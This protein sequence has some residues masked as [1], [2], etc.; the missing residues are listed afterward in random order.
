MLNFTQS[1]SNLP[2]MTTLLTEREAELVASSMPYDTFDHLDATVSDDHFDLACSLIPVSLEQVTEFLRYGECILPFGLRKIRSSLTVL[3]TWKAML[4]RPNQKDFKTGRP[5][6]DEFLVQL[7][8]VMITCRISR[9]QELGEKLEKHAMLLYSQRFNVS[10][11]HAVFAVCPAFPIVGTTPDGL[12]IE[13]DTITVVEVKSPGLGLTS[14]IKEVLPKVR[15]LYR[16]RNGH[17]RLCKSSYTYFQMQLTM[18][19]FG[20]YKAHLV[21]YSEFGNDIHVIYIDYDESFVQ[22][23]LVEIN[24]LYY[25]HIFPVVANFAI[26]Q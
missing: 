8:R 14:P 20:S 19:I 2:I 5:N 6:R 13:G 7:R 1:Y 16:A 25:N 22:K 10:V 26:K 11:K 23:K 9:P 17:Y 3:Y 15:S 24:E 4:D 18:F 12:V 21:Y